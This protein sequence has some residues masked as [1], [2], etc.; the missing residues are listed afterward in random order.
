M[1]FNTAGHSVEEKDFTS[2]Y[3]KPGIHIAKIAKIEHKTANGGT[4]GFTIHHEGKP[5]AELGGKGQKAE[6]TYWMSEKAW[7]FSKD[8]LV[9][10]ADKLGL[11]A[12]LD[13]INASSAKEYAAALNSIFAGKAARWK[14]AGEEVQGKEGKQN[15]FKAGLS[16][17]GFVEPLSVTESESKLKFDPSNKYDMKRLTASDV[18]SSPAGVT[19]GVVATTE[20][21]WS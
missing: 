2:E 15:W 9:I 4:E 19:N 5:M 7:P 20:E 18:E 10:M 17:Y 13:K 12:A 11:R 14:F 3:L 6:T 21:P 1:N 16:G 8:R